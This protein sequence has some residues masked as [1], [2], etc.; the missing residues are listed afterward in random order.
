MFPLRGRTAV[1]VS[2][3]SRHARCTSRRPA[4]ASVTEINEGGRSDSV[5]ALKHLTETTT[6]IFIKGNERPEHS[7]YDPQLGFESLKRDCLSHKAP[8]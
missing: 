7:V 3:N 5:A 4:P 1:L 6:L 8:V 2:L